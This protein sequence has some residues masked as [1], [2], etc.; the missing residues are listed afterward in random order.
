MFG[1]HAHEFRRALARRQWERTKDGIY[2]P[3]QHALLHGHVR[4]ESNHGTRVFR[5]IIMGEHFAPD[6]LLA[7]GGLAAVLDGH[8]V[9]LYGADVTPDAAWAAP[10]EGDPTLLGLTQYH[11][12][13]DLQELG[14]APEGY[15]EATRPAWVWADVGGGLLDNSAS[16]AA[17]TMRTA[18]TISVYGFAL[19]PS[20]G[21]VDGTPTGFGGTT[22]Y[23]TLDLSQATSADIASNASLYV[24][25]GA[26][27][28]DPGNS[29]A[30]DR[31]GYGRT[32]ALTAPANI[33]S[34][35]GGSSQYWHDPAGDDYY[36]A[37]AGFWVD[38]SGDSFFE[39]GLSGTALAV[40]R[41]PGA[42]LIFNDMDPLN[43]TWG[44][45]LTPV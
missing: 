9:A 13:N 19:I 17:F 10:Y 39:S 35:D 45:Q 43:V 14:D 25:V 6:T 3:R 18:G 30:E 34:Q 16:P 31:Y 22:L 20:S 15:D 40:A 28:T 11:L 12:W 33:I 37:G 42:P 21:K 29:G 4:T 5:N 2:F 27:D 32:I 38:P 24:P 1:R 44:I 26:N 23:S 41:A 8:Y 7:P 36:D